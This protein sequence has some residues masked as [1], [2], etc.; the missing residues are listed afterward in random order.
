MNKKILRTEGCKPTTPTSIFRRWCVTAII[1]CFTMS[2]NAQT[3]TNNGDVFHGLND[4]T[5]KT[6]DELI[7][8]ATDA[9]TFSM[10][11]PNKVFFLYNLETKQF[12]NSGSYWG[13]HVSLKYYGLPLWV[14]KIVK[15]SSWI[16]G[17]TYHTDHINFAQNLQTGQGPYIAWVL[18]NKSADDVNSGCYTDVTTGEATGWYFEPTNDG[19]NSYKMHV[20][21]FLYLL[22]R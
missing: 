22:T 7:Q 1:L 16:S 19:L 8:N 3:D 4:L 21:A 6:L 17:T 10:E 13:T 5:G 14:D 11:D 2:A 20:E 9:T 12:L 18:R 15:N